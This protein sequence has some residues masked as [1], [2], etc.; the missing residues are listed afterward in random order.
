MEGE[1]GQDAAQA[2]LL[3]NACMAMVNQSSLP[4]SI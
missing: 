2:L 3:C 1:K 4:P